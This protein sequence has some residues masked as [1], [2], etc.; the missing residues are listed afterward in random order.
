[1]INWLRRLSFLWPTG[2]ILGTAWA[3]VELVDLELLLHIP[4]GSAGTFVL[5][6]CWLVFPFALAFLWHFLLLWFGASSLTRNQIVHVQLASWLG[7]YL[8][9]K[10]GQ[11]LGKVVIGQR[12]GLPISIGTASSLMETFLFI[13]SGCLGAG[14]LLLYVDSPNTRLAFALGVIGVLAVPPVYTLL[15][16]RRLLNW[17]PVLP[18]LMPEAMAFQKWLLW[19]SGYLLTHF[20][21]AVGFYFL[22]DA[23]SVRD[24]IPGFFWL[25]S[26]VC[27]SH[28]AGILV[29]V[30]PAGIGAREAALTFL[31]TP[32][33]GLE[34]AA[35]VSAVARLISLAADAT[36]VPVYLSIQ[37]RCFQDIQKVKPS[38]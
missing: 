11:V 37:K 15:K 9:I 5:F 7:R 30:A 13:L 19:V 23:F 38:A 32:F 21:I 1:M 8:P 10:I 25:F 4:W 28:V 12:Y 34:T 18:D 33:M 31:L 2:I 6:V 20:I 24:S 36:L 22:L 14:L 17:V 3:A 29:F 26:V 35:T 27:F 16:Q